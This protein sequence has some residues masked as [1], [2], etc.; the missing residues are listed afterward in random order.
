MTCK[1]K[2]AIVTGA[3]GGGMGRSIALTL[4]REGAAVLV[5]YRT[6]AES[7]GQIV[8]HIKGRD[9]RAVAVEA[10]VFTQD[11]C[12]KLVD[13]ALAEFGR[14]DICVIG[15]GA[16]WHPSPPDKLD[17]PAALADA[18]QELAPLYNL[19]PLI[20]PGMYER[21]SGRIIALAVHPRELPP[22]Y[23]YNVAKA[24]RSAAVRLAASEG[25]PHGVTVNAIC[26]GPVEAI[27][28]LD[29]AIEQCARGPAWQK[30]ENT[31]PQDI[32]EGVAFL[33][34]DAGRFITGCELTYMFH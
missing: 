17:V 31:S 9:G 32:A 29:H 25:W 14:I 20:L 24:A 6:S 30:R 21:K 34:S 7:A 13:A 2:V 3:A 12:R 10:D 4:A 11:G 8:T 18:N 33:C 1:E 16:G 19:M 15:P 23:A 28:T 27:D 5:N 22:A 26:P